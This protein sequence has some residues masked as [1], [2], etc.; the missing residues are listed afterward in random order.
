MGW[1]SGGARG[2][3]PAEAP[4]QKACLEHDFLVTQLPLTSNSE[5]HQPALAGTL[6]A[7]YGAGARIVRVSATRGTPQALTA[8]FHSA[9]DP[10]V[11][12]DGK[13][14]LFAAQRNACDNW[15]IY[16]MAV[17][18]SGVRQITKNL[19][20]CRS[21]GYQSI[22]YEITE[23]FPWQ[24][25]T[26]VRSDSNTENE[27]GGGPVSSLYSCA[28]DGTK[29]RRLSFNL[30]SDYDP[31][32]MWDGRLLYASWQRASFD[33]G[34]PGRI[35]LL[36][37]N[38]DG[39]DCAAFVPDLGKRIKH[40]PC[41]TTGGL[42]VFVEADRVPWDGAGQLSGVRLRRPLHTY[43]EITGESDGL[44]HSPSPLPD[45]RI[46]VSR[47]PIDGSG[48]HAV[49]RLDPLS[50]R[51]ELI[52]DDP[53]WHD[54]QAKV[55]AP[56]A[57]PD[58]RSSSMNATD[59]LGKLYCLDV[60]T[61]DLKDPHRMSPGKAKRVRVIEGMPR[62]T[63]PRHVVGERDSF[64]GIPQLAPRRILGEIP[65]LEDHEGEVRE[66]YEKQAE[67]EGQAKRVV[68]GGSFNV[69]VPANTPIHLQLLDEHGVAL[70]SCGW[71]WVRNHQ[72]QGCIGCHEDGELTPTN[73]QVAALWEPFATAC[74]PP[75]LRTT[76][77]F[78]RDLVPLI[79]KKCTVCHDRQGSPPILIADPDSPAGRESN[80]QARFVYEALLA[81]AKSGAAANPYGQY[82]HPGRARTS[83]L[84]WHIFG[85]NLSAPWDG[86]A[87]NQS[88]KLIPPDR[89]PPW[90]DAER[91]LFVTWVDLG[92]PW[93]HVAAETATP[94]SP[95]AGKQKGRP[96]ECD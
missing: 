93:E 52:F 50:K 87:V 89:S 46:L 58:G 83:P 20:E 95:E 23:E 29:V 64:V 18:G 70:R 59:P 75:E 19:G 78:R 81:P 79:A 25:I 76:V 4:I 84:I 48:T 34:V 45:G 80:A 91:Q 38:A 74:P 17:D 2:S 6:R 12:F 47:R 67:G 11:S 69:E 5:P 13:R 1:T 43:Q 92:A 68:T 33:H 3:D 86:T 53:Q 28:L 44:F 40:M 60:Y 82:V 26:F 57:E 72:A 24:Q 51:L 21:P 30:S 63:T 85:R 90:S 27:F 65:I 54:I 16:E 88:A 31:C 66:Y 15:D 9:C 37:V 77:D 22:Y 32:V 42:A 94:A 62:N 36:G 7:R 61:S 10:D 14:V 35:N 96:R 71:I 39:A 8:G 49:Y 56:R 55:I 41:T 73:W